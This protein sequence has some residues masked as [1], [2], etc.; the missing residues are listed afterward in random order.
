MVVGEAELPLPG[1]D[2]DEWLDPATRPAVVRGDME[3]LGENQFWQRLGWSIPSRT[4]IG[5]TRRR[6]WPSCWE[7]PWP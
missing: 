4:S 2:L 5:F 1:G 7:S 3:I 6:C